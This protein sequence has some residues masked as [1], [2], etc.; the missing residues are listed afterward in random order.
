MWSLLEDDSVS[1]CQIRAQSLYRTD[2]AG[3]MG[4]CSLTDNGPVRLE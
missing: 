1:K 4:R 3:E 2:G